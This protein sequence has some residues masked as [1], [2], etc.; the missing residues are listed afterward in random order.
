MTI[1]I[2]PPT[3]GGTGTGYHTRVISSRSDC[4]KLHPRRH[5]DGHS[6]PASRCRAVAQLAGGIRA[7]AIGYTRTGYRAGI[8]PTRTNRCKSNPSGH[9]S[10]SGNQASGRRS[11]TDLTEA[12][13]APTVGHTRTCYRAGIIPTRTNRCKGNPSGHGS[14]SGNKASGRRS[15]TDL[16][17][18]VLAPTIGGTGT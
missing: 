6:S 5:G 15:I 14:G 3:I 1:E 17:E 18:V 11:I 12:V 4:L 13:Q 9:G 2:P 16:A 7:P 8:I 10:G